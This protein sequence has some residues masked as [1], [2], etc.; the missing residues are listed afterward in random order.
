MLGKRV[1]GVVGF[2]LAAVTMVAAQSQTSYQV[3][4]IGFSAYT[5]DGTSNPT[6]TLY[7]GVTY[8]FTV[9]AP[10]HP[11]WIKT[12]QVTGTGS[13]YSSGVT[14]NGLATG[15]VVFA[16]PMNAPDELYY[17]CEFHSSMTGVFQIE[18]APLGVDDGPAYPVEAA[19]LSSYPNPFNPATTIRFELPQAADIRVTIHDLLGQEIVRLVEGSLQAGSHRVVWDGKDQRGRSVPSGIYIARL[20]TPEYARSIRLVLLK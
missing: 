13:A 20:I 5:F 16:V 1:I 4:N 8:T 15:N 12:A 11:F 3:A 2:C 14:G 6:L 9:S 19:L 10:G 18:N 7:R 17:I